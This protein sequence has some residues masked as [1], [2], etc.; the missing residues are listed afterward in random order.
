MMNLSD[1]DQIEAVMALATID[2]GQGEVGL[3]NPG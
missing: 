1:I 3:E 2:L